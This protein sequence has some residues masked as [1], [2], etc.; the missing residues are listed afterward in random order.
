MVVAELQDVPLNVNAL[1]LL[2]TAAQK[3]GDGHDT[4]DMPIWVFGTGSS[5]VG[6]E[7]HVLPLNTKVD[8]SCA[9]TAMQ[10]LTV[11]HDADAS[12]LET[13]VGWL[14]VVPSYVTASPDPSTAM[15]K[16]ADGHDSDAGSR[17][18]WPLSMLTGPAHLGTALDSEAAG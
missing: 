4:D 2:S 8:E 9:S 10:K 11:G 17:P 16:L 15:Q 13:P 6:A 5:I 14:H 18:P 7:L 1:E 3:L 12:P